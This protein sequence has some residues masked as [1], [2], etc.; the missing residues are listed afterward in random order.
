MD[1][2]WH[3]YKGVHLYSPNVL[4]QAVF[5]NQRTCVSRNRYL[6]TGSE[7]DEIAHATLFD[8]REVSA[9]TFAHRYF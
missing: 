6:S 1:M 2:V 9:I 7:G 3:H 4:I 5:E 8:V